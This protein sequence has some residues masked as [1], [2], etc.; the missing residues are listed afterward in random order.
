MPRPRILVMVTVRAGY[1]RNII[2]GVYRFAS[3]RGG[4]DLQQV[5]PSASGEHINLDH[6]SG[7]VYQGGS[8]GSLVERLST[9]GLPVVDVSNWAPSKDVPAVTTDDE[10]AGGLAAEHLLSLGH[11]HFAFAGLRGGMYSQRRCD[12]FTRKVAHAGF[13]VDRFMLYE[14]KHVDGTWVNQIECTKAWLQGLPKPCGLLVCADQDALH[15]SQI[16]VSAGIAMP[17]EIAMVGVDDDDLVCELSSPALTSVRTD[18]VGVGMAA[19]QAIDRMLAGGSA[20]VPRRLAP[21]GVTVRASTEG[22]PIGDAVVRTAVAW[23]RLHAA[24]EASLTACAQAAGVSLR[25]LQ[26]RCAT[27][28]GHGPAEEL[29][30][31]RLDRAARLLAE[32]DLPLKAVAH[33]TGFA[34]AAYLCTAFARQRGMTPGTWRKQHAKAGS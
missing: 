14:G 6:F 34:S 7:V 24:G 31:L 10:A 12:G 8:T 18:G 22:R 21:L 3:L 27:A 33:R 2:R 28:L 32:T 16:A 20:E 29:L 26:S 13:Q 9:A 17:D 25:T 11:R 5:E 1:F 15:V 23:L 4:W 19:G 30:L